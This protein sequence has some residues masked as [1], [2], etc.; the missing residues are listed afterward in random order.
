MERLLRRHLVSIVGLVLAGLIGLAAIIDHIDKGHRMDRAERL[1]WY[2][3]HQ[4]TH[5]G[6]PSS[7]RIENDWN[8]RQL[9]Y[10]IAVIA[11][12]GAALA[13]IVVRERRR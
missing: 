9:G 10:E 2:C 8:K 3:A 13:R 1:E 7:E 4:G 6:G 11:I 5:C 12:G